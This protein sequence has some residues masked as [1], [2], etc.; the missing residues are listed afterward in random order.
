MVFQ[1]AGVS[2]VVASVV[3]KS[4]DPPSEVVTGVACSSLVSAICV[5]GSTY[6]AEAVAVPKQAMTRDMKSLFICII[7]FVE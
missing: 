1:V 7:C 3:E 2:K 6:C 5:E 4:V